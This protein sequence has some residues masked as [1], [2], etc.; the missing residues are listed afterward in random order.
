M[1]NAWETLIPQ[2]IDDETMRSIVK[3][4]LD[5]VTLHV[6]NFYARKSQIAPTDLENLAKVDSKLLPNPLPDLMVDSNMQLLAIKHCITFTLTNSIVPGNDPSDKILP[7]YLAALPRGFVRDLDSET[8]T[9][10]NHHKI[11]D[12]PKAKADASSSLP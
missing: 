12:R 8:D 9:R 11:I 10:G 2:P 1:T 4:L 5:R 7:I 6:D 3:S